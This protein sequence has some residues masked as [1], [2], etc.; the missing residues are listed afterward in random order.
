M[1]KAVPEDVDWHME[2]PK[3]AMQ[4][5]ALI[6][7]RLALKTLPSLS[8]KKR[9]WGLCSQ[10]WR[11]PFQAGIHWLQ[12]AHAFSQFCSALDLWVFSE[13]AA[14]MTFKACCR[15]SLYQDA[16]HSLLC[17]ACTS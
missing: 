4:M 3:A 5:Q 16:Q 2:W 9:F 12:F 8:P 13:R 15:N 7:V 17:F 14:L 11:S 1:Q 6:K 10:A